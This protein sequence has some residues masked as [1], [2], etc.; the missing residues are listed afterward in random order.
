MEKVINVP[1]DD[2][3]K[4]KLEDR[5]DANGRATSREAAQLIKDGL[6]KDAGD[7]KRK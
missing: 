7:G 4:K 5:A 1:L 6:R 2:E 3:T